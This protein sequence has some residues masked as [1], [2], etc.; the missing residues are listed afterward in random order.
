[1]AVNTHRLNCSNA[2]NP[3]CECSG[4]GGSLHGWGG[5]ATLA[6]ERPAIRDERR[7]ALKDDITKEDAGALIFNEKNRRKSLDLARLDLADYLWD[8]DPRPKG[9]APLPRRFEVGDW[10]AVPFDN[11]RM[12]ILADEVMGK[13]WDEISD[14][15]GTLVGN[16]QTARNIKKDL[17]SHGWCSLLVALIQLIEKV[18]KAIGLI[19]DTVKQTLKDA[20]SKRFTC[21]I[22]K[23][24]KDAVVDIV[25][26]RVWSALTRLLDAH[27]PL[28]GADT[29]RVLRMLAVFACPS[30]ER[31]RDVYQHALVPLMADGRGL[32]AEEVK[33][34]VATLFTAWW[35]RKGLATAP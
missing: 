32:V 23:Q 19:A 22:A 8:A 10:E 7:R 5:W 20:L 33:A 25:V 14:S 34:Q 2:Q 13:P 31:H 27:F 3:G 18:N 21:R 16:K 4:C 29:V 6:V 35:Q 12:N 1:M 28:L 17:A 15:I 26:D 9:D 24:L 30:V 11:G